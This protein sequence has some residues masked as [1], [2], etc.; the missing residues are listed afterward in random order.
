MSAIP[1]P[2]GG[3]PEG[4]PGKVRIKELLGRLW[5]LRDDVTAAEIAA[6]VSH[7]FTGRISDAQVAAL[8]LCLHATGLERRPDVLAA[9]AAAMR[10]A[11]AP[12]DV[13]ALHAVVAERGRPE[14]S[15]KGGMVSTCTYR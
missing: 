13:A 5:P 12:V 14:G 7:I 4:T 10:A 1:Q 8:L 9:C 15:Y 2:A 3:P 11:A 6:A